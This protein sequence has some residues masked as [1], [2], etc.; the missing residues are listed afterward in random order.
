MDTLSHFVTIL[1]MTTLPKI[2]A[3][4]VAYQLVKI[5]MLMKNQVFWDDIP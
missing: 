3:T 1:G 4:S 5:A 2:A